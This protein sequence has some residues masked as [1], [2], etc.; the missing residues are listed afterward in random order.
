MAVS[1][2]ARKLPHANVGVDNQSF[3][4]LYREA[5][6]GIHQ[7]AGNQRIVELNWTT[8]DNLPNQRSGAAQ[9]SS[10]NGC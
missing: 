4:R 6:P 1:G 3:E 7:G 8:S 5:I 10:S 9:C 2:Q